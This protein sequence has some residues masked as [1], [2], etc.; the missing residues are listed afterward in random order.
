[1]TRYIKT[2]NAGLDVVR[3]TAILLVLVCHILLR[4]EI[5]YDFGLSYHSRHIIGWF[6]VELFFILSGFLIGK[7]L[8]EDFI[9]NFN[10]NSRAV[11]SN[12]YKRRWFRTLPLYYLFLIINIII[13]FFLSSFMTGFDR[14]VF[15]KET[16]PY[17][18][19][20]QN[21]SGFANSDNLTL[22]R[23]SWS[24]VIE[25]WFYLLFPL[26]IIALRKIFDKTFTKQKFLGFLILF[27]GF[28]TLLRVFCVLSSDLCFFGVAHSVFLRLD[29]FAVGILLAYLHTFMPGIYSYI[30]RK[31]FFITSIALI[32]VLWFVV[33]H[34]EKNVFIRIFA[35]NLLPASIA[36]FIAYI[37]NLDIKKINFFNFTS[38]ISYSLY[39]GHEPLL[40][41]FIFGL[42]SIRAIKIPFPAV[43][44]IFLILAYITAY[45]SY[46]RYEK[47][48][49]DL[50]DID[51]T[52]LPHR[53]K[54]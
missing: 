7:I 54:T 36:V 24:L 42:L 14:G 4:T 19:F 30:A 32:G 29:T 47:P 27:I 50:R 45:I 10:G 23:V 44:I 1:M 31:R 51:K 6:G 21:F 16:A 26:F 39:L 40:N 9:I 48:I 53:I 3:S 49:M 22:M 2:R 17:F 35:F 46:S 52:F 28:I 43:L 34:Y 18:L 33:L 37:E 25:E 12:F 8:I 41:Y 20:L 15:F 5:F 11:L 38:K 13:V